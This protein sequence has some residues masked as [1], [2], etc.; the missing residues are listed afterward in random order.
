MLKRIKE[1]VRSVRFGCGEQCR[2][3]AMTLMALAGGLVCATAIFFVFRNAELNRA[4]RDFE[5][6]AL[7]RIYAIQKTLEYDLQA[8]RSLQAF[9]LGSD[10]VNKDEFGLFAATLMDDHP[11]LFSMHWAPL[12][13]D[14]KGE[15]HFPIHYSGFRDQTP[16]EQKIALNK[17]LTEIAG[18]MVLKRS[19][20]T[21]CATVAYRISSSEETRNDQLVLVLPVYYRHALLRTT[22]ERQTALQGFI[23]AVL[24]LPGIV[25]EAMVRYVPAGVEVQLIDESDPTHPRSLFHHHSRLNGDVSSSSYRLSSTPRSVRLERAITFAG[26]SWAIRC[27]ASPEFIAARTTWL[28]WVVAVFSLALAGVLAAY[29]VNSSKRNLTLSRL[30]VLLS[31]NNQRLESEISERKSAEERQRRTLIR[32][33]AL[34]RLQENLLLPAPVEEKLRRITATAAEILGLDFCRIWL[35][36]RGDRCEEDCPCAVAEDGK[37]GCISQETCF[38]LVASSGRYTHLNGEHSR[39]PL[40]HFKASCLAGGSGKKYLTNNA[41]AD[42]AIRD[43]E[44][45]KRLGLVSFAAYKLHEAK[46]N[47]TGV[48]AAFAQHPLSNED[49]AFLSTLADTAS[50]IILA[51][52]AETAMEAERAKLRAMISGMEEG[53]VFASARD[54]IIEVNDFFC[55]FVN[56]KPGEILGRK[57]EE[58]HSESILERIRPI[59]SQFRSTP[60]SP[61]HVIQRS[62]KG[63]DLVLRLQ[64]IY[65]N[66]RYDGVLLNMIDVSEL[67]LAR[68]EAEAANQAKSRFLASMSHE[69]RNPM[70]AILGYAELLMDPTLSE[71]SR[72]NY[73]AVIRRNGEHLLTL[74]NDI[75]DLSKIE[76]GKFTITLERCNLVALLADVAGVVRPRAEGRGLKLSVEYGG[77]VPE[78][79][80]TDCARLRQALIN[81]VGNAVK[82]TERGSVRIVASFL[83]GWRDG[84]NAVKIEVIDTGVGIH[85]DVLP[86]LF[87][88]FSQGDAT[89]ARKFGGTGL[90]LAISRHIARL[91]GGDLTAT[92]IWKKGSTFTLIV[93]TGDLTGVRMLENPAEVEALT[94]PATQK[95]TAKV[96]KGVNILLAEDGPD[97]RELIRTLL[98]SAGAQVE[99]VENGREAVEAAAAKKYDVILMDMNMPV[100]DG[101]EATRILRDRGYDR[102]ILALTAN[103]M[104]SDV[105]QCLAAGC[106]RH[107]AKPIDRERLIGTIAAALGKAAPEAVQERA[108]TLTP[109]SPENMAKEAVISLYADDPDVAG[110]LEDFIAR[111]SEQITDMQ[112]AFSEGRYEELARLAHRLKGAG[113]SYGYPAL[114]DAGKSLEDAAKA[115]NQ[116]AI[117][118]ALETITT[119]SVAIE[120]GYQALVSAGRIK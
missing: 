5:H 103:A 25:E 54:E 48:L 27:T 7:D 14:P 82:F 24:Y 104:A 98:Q 90:G 89:V 107:I 116:P 28:P 118:A 11:S 66:G 42:P 41:I 18:R 33:E 77:A 9:F 51:A 96:L 102:P 3:Q 40:E 95:Q 47:P 55:R 61:P 101:Y 69:I 62:I 113:G 37:R 117:A 52:A 119:L 12:S 56:L 58:F 73:L 44:W 21:G 78:T 106:N 29:L 13:S 4:S 38:H 109:S 74:I 30:T 79:I 34:N 6:A 46:G 60:N 8:L 72:A 105:E 2:S 53:V 59:L 39:L 22:A 68:R 80:L 87:Q 94:L 32:L 31:E 57:L 70:T 99:A 43:H 120:H 111:L 88:P 49:D 67:V 108:T 83:A 20:E 36:R 19:S 100:M 114:T 1:L 64:P 75:L 45:A 93:P 50:N 10:E 63:T 23:A 17:D 110:I 26:R 86:H 85:P 35:A 76:A 65:C 92:S 91:L 97:N 15:Q 112:R 81:L 115:H 16:D 84:Q 71:S